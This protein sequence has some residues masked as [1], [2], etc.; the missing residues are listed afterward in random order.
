MSR[1]K[2]IFESAA[3]IT[4]TGKPSLSSIGSQTDYYKK[5]PKAKLELSDI[6]TA[7][8]DSGI[9][10]GIASVGSGAVI[11]LFGGPFMAGVYVG[12]AAG[13]IRY[14]WN[15]ECA[16]DVLSV[17]E[18]WKKDDTLPYEDDNDGEPASIEAPTIRVETVSPDNKHWLIEDLNIDETK[19]VE[20]AK[21][22]LIGESLSERTAKKADI[23]REEWQPLRDKFIR[24]KLAMWKKE[25]SPRQ[26]SILTGT[27]RRFC[28]QITN[29]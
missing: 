8:A 4:L 25:G 18:K 19:L 28:Q 23:S 14:Y 11:A 6:K 5:T 22:L 12:F 2:K 1:I 7:L 9:I 26:G 24:A 15:V 20:L 29:Q 21:L 3:A 13:A 10:F 16:R 27:G 17:I